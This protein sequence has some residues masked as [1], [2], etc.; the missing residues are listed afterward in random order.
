CAPAPAAISPRPTGATTSGTSPVPSGSDAA[1]PSHPPSCASLEAPPDEGRAHLP[2]G[3]TG[4]YDTYPPTS[5]PHAI[6]PAKPGWYDE[7]PPIEQLVHS[8]EHGFIVVYRSGLDATDEAALKTRFDAL[9][10]DGF[11]ALISVPDE[12]IKDPM[13]LTAWDRLQRCVKADPDAFEGF[14][15]DHYAQAPEASVAC[16]VQGAAGLPVCQA[17]LAN[18]SPAPSRSPTSADDALLTRIPEALR[19]PCRPTSILADGADGGWDCFPVGGDLLYG[20]A[21]FPSIAA[22]DGYFDG[23]VSTLGPT[24]TGDCATGSTGVG[25]FKR[26]DGSSGRLACAE[27]NGTRAYYWTIDGSN[28]LGAARARGDADLR[29]FWQ[30]A[31]PLQT[32]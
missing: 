28:D 24:P 20:Y 17:L 14:V 32:P 30:A 1:V 27:T 12:S 31:G 10:A 19:P 3:E 25:P 5:G 23:L 16:S 13:T 6:T 2:D 9:V 4:S 21:S 22:R 11:G 7:S 15:R 8:L 26:A 29:A 18:N